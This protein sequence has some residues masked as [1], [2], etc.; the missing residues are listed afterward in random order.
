M[1]GIGTGAEERVVRSGFT[2]STLLSLIVAALFVAQPVSAGLTSVVEDPVGD[3]FVDN[4]G[5]PFNAYQDIVQAAV[6]LKD[7]RF[8]VAMKLAGSVPSSPVLP[9]QI[10]LLDWSWYI[11]TDPTTFPA[12]FPY[13][14][15]GA[16]SPEFIVLL[17]WDGTSFTT[18]LIDRRPLL[19]GGQALLTPVPFLIKGSVITASVDAAQ[20]DNPSSFGWSALTED[21]ETQLGTNSFHTIDFTAAAQWPA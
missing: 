4:P 17:V 15:G 18:T 16:P 11:N 5:I 2:G 19:T 1:R 8:I 21:W 14:P 10:V 3:A 20:L 6:T 7:G 9:P 12:G 13:S